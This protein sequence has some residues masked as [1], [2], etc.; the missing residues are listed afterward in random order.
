M[1]AC[2]GQAPAKALA[3]SREAVTVWRRLAKVNPA[4]HE[5]SLAASLGNLSVDQWHLGLREESL[6]A[7]GE[8][9]TLYR[10]LARAN[11]VAYQAAL[12]AS[13]SDFGGRL[14]EMGRLDQALAPAREAVE[15]GRPLAG[16]DPARDPDFAM[17]LDNLS[18]ILAGSVLKVK[19]W[20]R[21]WKP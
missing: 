7:H 19:P 17:A 4:A 1:P 18:I 5:P 12:A 6:S 13:L 9:V 8:L 15:I 3:A 11:P 16:A 10:R 20:P 21:T 2:P 14:S